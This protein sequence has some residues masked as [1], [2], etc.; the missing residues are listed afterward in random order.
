[1]VTMNK[2]QISKW[3]DDAKSVCEQSGARLT[4]KRQDILKILLIAGGPLSAYQIANAYNDGAQKPMPTM[5]VYRILEFLETKDLVHKLSSNN[6][7]IACTHSHNGDTRKVTQFLICNQCKIAKEIIIST[8]I[9]DE[10]GKVV[11]NAGFALKHRQLEL[12]CLCEECS[13]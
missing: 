3:I 13:A 11:E 6:K 1:M 2:R 9:M 10:L 4:E 12:D 7:Y 8:K 5:S